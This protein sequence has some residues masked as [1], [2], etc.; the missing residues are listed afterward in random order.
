MSSRLKTTLGFTL[1]CLLIIF[2]MIQSNLSTSKF[3]AT[4]HWMSH[5]VDIQGKI[6]K[7]STLF[8]TVQ[9]NIRGYHLS[10]NTSYLDLHNQAKSELKDRL[11]KLK[12]LIGENPVQAENIIQLENALNE[13]FM[14]WE[15][16]LEIHKRGGVKAIQNLMLQDDVRA[17]DTSTFKALEN[18]SKEQSRLLS[19]Q[20]EETQIQGRNTKWMIDLVGLFACL[21]IIF[22]T[23][24]VFRDSRQRE[25]AEDSVDRFFTL[26]LDLL[27][28]A[29]MDGYFKRLSPSFSETLGFST[30][31]LTSQPIMNFVHPE[32]VAKSQNEIARQS[33]GHRVYSFENR[34]R[35]RNGEYKIFSWKSVPVG[36][37]MYAVARDITQQK[38]NEQDLTTAREVAQAS[39]VA[40]ST[41]LANMSHEIRTPLNGVV[42]MVELLARTNLAEEQKK[43]VGAIRTSASQLLRIVNEVLDFSKLEVGRVHIDN[44]DFELDHLLEEYLS[45]IGV[46]AKEKG[47]EIETRIDPNI[48]NVLRGDSGK[49]NQILLNFVNNAIKFTNRG[50][51]VIAAD[52]VSLEDG[53]CKTKLSVRDSGIGMSSAQKAILFEPYVQAD[54]TTARR[55]GGTGLGLSISKRFAENMGGKVG[56]ES[57]PGMGSTFWVVIP[58]EVSPLKSLR[59]D[60]NGN[61]HA[62][63]SE[64]SQLPDEATL[65]RRQNIRI[66]IAEDIRMNQIIIMEMMQILGFNATLVQNGKEALE[67]YTNYNFDLILMDHHM[68]VMDGIEASQEIRNLERSSSR[69]IPIVAFTATVIQENEKDDFKSLIDD[70]I[71]KP[72]S[73]ETLENLM[74]RWESR[75]L[76]QK[77]LNL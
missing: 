49:V 64:T 76:E 45:V 23:W 19:L 22:A 53:V 20:A 44:L 11:I 63:R 36:Q 55:Y 70:F 21:I 48:P 47:L 41:F 73:I 60:G 67:H 5:S 65:R 46:L 52:L 57:T 59:N 7:L 14:L 25:L 17:Q 1:A 13:K 75:I 40:K 35:C 42:G 8:A 77:N 12:G 61:G 4:T 24:V 71:L 29:G 16:S 58:F 33:K 34:F 50:K 72:V 9:N 3:I 68:P 62:H 30:Q 31:E 32:D 54:N 27:C 74:Q 56:V 43:Y 69:R 10:G 39:T 6:E 38:K 28:I 51:I 2:A 18:L 37:Y 66:L 26:S 15:S